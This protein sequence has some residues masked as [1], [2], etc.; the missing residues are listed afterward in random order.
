MPER[1]STTGSPIWVGIDLGTQSVR[2]VAIDDGGAELAIASAPLTSTRSGVRH[3][4]DPAQWWWAVCDVLRQVTGRL[5]DPSRIRALAVSATSGTIV[6]VDD[7]GRPVTA[8]LMY[9]D[10]RGAEYVERIDEAGDEVW[11]RLGYRMQG[12]WALPKIVWLRENGVLTGSRTIAFQHDLITAHLAGRSLPSDSSHALKAGLDLDSLRWPA[13]VLAA[14][15]L[16]ETAL[17]EVV[18]SGTVIGHVDAAAASDTGLPAGCA[19]VA[20]MTD[21]CAAQLAVGAL[22]PG[23]WNSVLGTTLVVKGMSR[24]R[25]DDPTGAVYAHRAPF[26]AGWFPGGASS[27]GAGAVTHW[28]PDRDLGAL[29]TEASER[30]TTLSYPL[31]G[32]GERFPFVAPQAHA[33]FAESLDD[34]GRFSAIAHGVALVER[35]CYDLLDLCGYDVTGP[36]GFTGGGAKNPWWNQL[37]CDVLQ[38]EAR[39]P[40][41]GEGVFGMAVLA[42]AGM[43]ETA[44]PDRRLEAAAARLLP[45]AR[46]L[47]PGPMAGHADD[48]RRFVDAIRAEDWLGSDLHAHALERLR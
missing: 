11:R 32:T 40:R 2:A 30:S 18:A 43:D 14:L 46:T 25:H 45:P 8:G 17:P 20:G 10:A 31:V 3:E 41:H 28:L 37:R 15:D 35:L 48:Y 44:A 38:R 1:E 13:R 39:I 33:L 12:S 16:P 27:T 7:R 36:V 29:T 4:Q 21:G 5:D 19:I 9:D 22:A 26:G 24:Q 23:S 47:T 34:A 42:A 6:V